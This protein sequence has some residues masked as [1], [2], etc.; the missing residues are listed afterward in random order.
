MDDLTVQAQQVHHLLVRLVVIV[1]VHHYDN[2]D[3]LRGIFDIIFLL[4]LLNDTTDLLPK[5]FVSSIRNL[6]G[7]DRTTFHTNLALA[8]L[9]TLNGRVNRLLVLLT[10]E[11]KQ[12]SALKVLGVKYRHLLQQAFTGKESLA[13]AFI[14]FQLWHVQA[15][16]V[17]DFWS[18]LQR[19]VKVFPFA[20]VVQVFHEE[21]E[22]LHFFVRLLT[23]GAEHLPHA[24]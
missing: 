12:V 21:L 19:D 23:D 2:K 24:L 16:A 20:H 18:L 3:F 10:V 4:E 5:A 6:D 11:K 1:M 13:V 15:S 7:N 9:E 8:F 22:T 14:V 17:E